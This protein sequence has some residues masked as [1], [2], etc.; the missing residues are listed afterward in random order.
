MPHD[1][2]PTEEKLTA[3]QAK[4]ADMLMS[5]PN[6]IGIAIGFIQ[7]GGIATEEKGIVVMVS[8]KMPDNQVPP[9][10]R[11]PAELD[12]VRVDVQEF[13]SFSAQ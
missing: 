5:K 7:E 13:G 1:E 9:K 10:D 6:V 8:V 4:Y 11:I 12:G 3:V 2:Q